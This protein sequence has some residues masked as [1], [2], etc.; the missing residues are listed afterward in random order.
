MK[1]PLLTTC[2]N[3]DIPEDAVKHIRNVYVKG[4]KDTGIRPLSRLYNVAQDTIRAA[5]IHK[6]WT[7]I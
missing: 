4:S 6:T 1:H 2:V 5:V 7:H 3:T